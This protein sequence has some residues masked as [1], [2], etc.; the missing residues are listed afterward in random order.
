[1][2][3]DIHINRTYDVPYVSGCS[4]DG[5][6]VYIDRKLPEKF[7]TSDMKVIYWTKYLIVHEV[8]EFALMHRLGHDYSHSHFV[9]TEAEIASCIDDRTPVDEYLGEIWQW[10]LKLALP[11]NIRRTPPDLDLRPYRESG[12][13]GREL[14]ELM[15]KIGHVQL[16]G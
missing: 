7:I 8:T 10:C 12:E 11:E 2:S 3:Q 9:A 1:M 5:S 13:P 16:G 6:V 14:V 4:T 15:R